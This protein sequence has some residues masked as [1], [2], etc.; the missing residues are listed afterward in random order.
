[1]FQGSLPLEFM[2]CGDLFI[3]KDFGKPAGP[4]N[5]T[6]FPARICVK[7]PGDDDGAVLW[8]S[9][10][11]FNHKISTFFLHGFVKIKMH[12]GHDNPEGILLKK[13]DDTLP[14]P[15]AARQPGFDIR[16]VAYE[17]MPVP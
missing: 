12:I 8:K 17:M 1:M 9:G 5:T 14:G 2:K 10:Q 4:E 7:I 3:V 6:G 15:F 13:T 11:K 16:R